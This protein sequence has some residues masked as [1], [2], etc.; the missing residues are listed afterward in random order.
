MDRKFIKKVIKDK[1][2]L[3]LIR[4]VDIKIP[5]IAIFFL[6]RPQKQYEILKNSI[7]FLNEPFTYIDGLVLVKFSK[8]TP[9]KAPRNYLMF[10][11]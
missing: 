10:R 8:K 2:K 4:Q 6:Y 1:T 11:E 9:H 7:N 3:G 5:E